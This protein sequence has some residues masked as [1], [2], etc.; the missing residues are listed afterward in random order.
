MGCDITLKF[1]KIQDGRQSTRIVLIEGQFWDIEFPTLHSCI[2]KLRDAQ[3]H[4]I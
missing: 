1:H 3:V 2:G 4:E